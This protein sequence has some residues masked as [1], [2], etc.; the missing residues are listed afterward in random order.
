MRA[1]LSLVTLLLI[2]SPGTTIAEEEKEIGTFN[3]K[4][5]KRIHGDWKKGTKNGDKKILEQYWARKPIFK[6][7][8]VGGE[9]NVTDSN[10]EHFVEI[11]EVRGK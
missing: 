9:R 2:S 1:L 11:S 3:P 8:I 10:D 7:P 4:D 6:G 5:S